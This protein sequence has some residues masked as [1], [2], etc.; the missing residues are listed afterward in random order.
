[1]KTYIDQQNNLYKINGTVPLF[2]MID[3]VLKR[4]IKRLKYLA[5]VES[6]LKTSCFQSG[7]GWSTWCA[8][9]RLG[10][11]VNSHCDERKNYYKSRPL[12]D[13]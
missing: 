6:E 3:A 13:I 11:G 5:V 9:A 7:C 1:V 4:M 10:F 12:Q 2:I 8:F